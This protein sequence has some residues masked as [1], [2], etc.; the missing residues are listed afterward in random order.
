MRDL[1]RRTNGRIHS[2]RTTEN[3]TFQK[4]SETKVKKM[5]KRQ[6]SADLILE[7][8]NRGA[9]TKINIILERVRF[10]TV[11]VD[12]IGHVKDDQHPLDD[13]RSPSDVPGQ[14]QP[15]KGLRAGPRFPGILSDFSQW[16]AASPYL[17]ESSMPPLTIYLTISDIYSHS[18]DDMIQSLAMNLFKC[19][20][21][22]S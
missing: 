22:S 18:H 16:V 11:T 8:A 5:V 4:T 17:E 6:A 15:T 21:Y 1:T 7:D 14:V 13:R 20:S 2:R 9:S 10:A 19:I 3:S 12:S